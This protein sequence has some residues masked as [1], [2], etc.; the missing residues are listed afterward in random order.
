MIR[1]AD[2]VMKR[3]Y[4]EQIDRLFFVPGGSCIF[5][6]DA[7]RRAEGI[8]GVSMQHEQAAAMAA[9][10]YALYENKMGA[11]I[12]TTGCGGTNTITGVLHAWQDSIPM[13]VISGQQN[14]INKLM[15][16]NIH[17]YPYKFQQI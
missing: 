3:L 15:P 7:L 1:V 6:T 2:Y 5:L 12:V 17:I 16:L 8:K 4:E 14:Y 13:I 10:S 11:C 9:L